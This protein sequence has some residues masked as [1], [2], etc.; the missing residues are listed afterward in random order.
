MFL[1]SGIGEITKH[2]T[3]G[4]VTSGIAGGNAGVD[5]NY[6]LEHLNSLQYWN[7]FSDHLKC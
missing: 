3:Y 4:A 1:G 7:N 6:M 5:V 2:C